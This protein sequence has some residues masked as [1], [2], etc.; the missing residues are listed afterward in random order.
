MPFGLTGAPSVF[1]RLMDCILSGL[2]YITCLVYLDD[3]IIFGR[4]FDEQLERLRE[5]FARIRQANLKLKPTKCSLFRLI[6]EP[7]L[8]LPSDHGKY[9]LDCDASDVG[10]G[11]VLSQEQSGSEHVI[12]YASRSLGRSECNYE[13]TRKELL[14]IIYGLKQFRQYLAGRHFVIRTDHAALSWLRRTPEPMPQLARWLTFIEEFNYEVVHRDGRKH[15][16]ADGL[17]RRPH[18]SDSEHEHETF[19][20][21]V[22]DPCTDDANKSN[23]DHEFVSESVEASVRESLAEQQKRDSDIGPIVRLRLESDV[24][25]P[26]SD[27]LAASET[28][29]RLYNEWER[30]QVRDGL[31]YRWRDGKPGE[32]PVLQLL[33]P[34]SHVQSVLCSSHG[35][36]TGGHF[37]IKRTLDQVKRRFYWSSWKSDTVRF[38]KRCDLCNEYHRGKLGRQAPLQPVLAGAP[39]ERWYIDLTGPHPRSE[40]GHLYI[41]TC[42]DAFTKW[43]EAFPIRNK[44]AETVARVLVEQVFCRFGTPVSVL[45][46]QGKEVDGNI[47]RGICRMLGIDKLRT[48]PYKPSTNQVERLHRSLNAVLGKMV[49]THQRDWDTR[50]SF[51]MAA[52][53][54]SRNEATGYT[55]NMLTLGREVRMPVDIVYGSLED[56]A[57]E[58]Y[59]DYVENVRER[60]T[61][62]YEEA[63][64]AL[65]KAAERNKRYYDVRVRPNTFKEGDWVLYFNPRKFVGKQDKWVR[66]YTGPFLVVAIPSAVTVR[67]Q[68]RKGAKPFTVH[69]DK[70]KHFMGEHPRPWTEGEMPCDGN[71]QPVAAAVPP[72]ETDTAATVPRR[73]R[74]PAGSS[75]DLR[76]SYDDSVGYAVDDAIPYDRPTRTRRP[77]RY[78]DEYVRTTREIQPDRMEAN[79]QSDIARL[80][81]DRLRSGHSYEFVRS[82][83]DRYHFSTNSC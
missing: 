33:V 80:W 58:S 19:V 15:A 29:K 18:A 21:M 26:L 12:A 75:V 43:A 78:L 2:S 55:P 11:A 20:K 44:E 30:L 76:E 13:T 39:Y 50:L 61:S 72:T 74:P 68:R 67:L 9:I 45:S 24:R 4:T 57:N 81:E 53:R 10:L 48:S 7:V 56:P 32:H 59:D 63:R 66:K 73:A 16:N 70:V 51:A 77:P 23:D 49:A 1:Q 47:M 3:I 17:S 36:H 64:Q 25:P 62:A 65:R 42:I 60:M 35:G 31:V 28:A 34:R 14:A 37:G 54:A 5:V 6:S 40:H 82:N 79:Q 27:L 71:D 46:D 83:S 8:T 22:S 38:C 41:L 52:Y 69:I